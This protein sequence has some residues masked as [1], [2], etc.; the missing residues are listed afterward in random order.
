MSGLLVKSTVIMKDNLEEMNARGLADLPTLLGGAALTRGYVEDDLRAHLRGRRLLLQGR[1]RGAAGPR[2]GHGGPKEGTELPEELAGRNERRSRRA[3]PRRRSRRPR[4]AGPA[5]LR[6]GHRRRD[7]DPPFWGARVVARHQRRRDPPA[8]E[9]DRAVPQPVGLHAR[10]PLAGG[11]P[12]AAR[13]ARLAGAAR[14]DRPGQ[15]REDPHP[16]RS[17]TATGRPTATATTWWCGSPTRRWRRSWCASA[18]RARPGAGSSTSPTSS[19]TSTPA[20]PTCSPPSA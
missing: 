10:R 9:R 7:P 20:C 15:G 13:G 3:P 17:C 16:R 11:V 12:A 8:A 6:G 2:H 19:V 5:A 18:S 1:L 4:R 14:P